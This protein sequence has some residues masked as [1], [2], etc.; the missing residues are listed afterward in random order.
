M[1]REGKNN[2]SIVK[3]YWLYQNNSQVQDTT[4]ASV[5]LIPKKRQAKHMKG[6]CVASIDAHAFVF[7]I[8]ADRRRSTDRWA[9][10][11][12]TEQ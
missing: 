6:I 9:A 8:S 7:L 11:T 2:R 4:V 3:H 12:D 10:I 5:V 1:E